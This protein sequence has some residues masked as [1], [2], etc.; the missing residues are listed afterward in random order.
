MNNARK[1]MLAALALCLFSSLS[2]KPNR[3]N[4]KHNKQV[5]PI[6]G[7]WNLTFAA[8]PVKVTSG[9]DVLEATEETLELDA[10]QPNGNKVILEGVGTF[11][12]DGTVVI[13]S[14]PKE[15]N[16]VQCGIY[17]TMSYG[18]WKKVDKKHYKV[19]LSSVTNPPGTTDDF[20]GHTV[21]HFVLTKECKDAYL[22]GVFGIHPL[23]DICFKSRKR[24]QFKLYGEACKLS[25]CNKK[26][27][28]TL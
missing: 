18:I 3:K 16:D 22:S 8:I 20:R 27:R 6:V 24:A 2:A 1:S 25:F 11:H 17:S 7:T 4:H 5:D 10:T 23:D 9:T 14:I 15:P 13:A 12:R 26:K 19:V 28:I 21:A